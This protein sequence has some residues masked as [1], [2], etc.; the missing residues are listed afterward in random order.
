MAKQITL[1]QALHC[2]KCGTQATFVEECT[3]TTFSP[4][5]ITLIECSSCREKPWIYC[6][7]CRIRCYRNGLL[8]HAQRKKHIEQHKKVYPTPTIPPDP[9]AGDNAAIGPCPAEAIDDIDIDE[10]DSVAMDADEFHEQMNID[11]AATHV[12]NATTPM[13]ISEAKNCQIPS[14]RNDFPEINLAGNQWLAMAMEAKNLA[15]IQD[16]FNAF[17]GAGMDR[18]KNF[19]VAELGSGVG[20]CGGGAKYLSA[21]GFQ[22]SKDSQLDKQRFPDLDEALWHL[23]KM[24]QYQSMNKKQRIRQSRIDKVLLENSKANVFF[25][26][27]F[28]PTYSQLG[29]FYGTT[30]K[31]S[32]WNNLPV[33]KSQDVGG[34]AYVHPRAAIAYLL[35]NGIPI[36]E[37]QLTDD[38][39]GTIPYNATVHNARECRKAV[40]WFN[41][42]KRDYYGSH[43]IVGAPNSKNGAPIFPTVI[44]LVVSDWADGFGP[45]KVKNNRNSV[46]CKTITVSPPRNTLSTSLNTLPVAM[47]LKKA[48]G[49]A[50]VERLFRK[51]LEELTSTKEP[52]LFYNG[53]IQKVIPCFIRRFAVL[54]DKIERNGLTGT[55]GCGSDIHR[56]FAY[57]G[58]IQTP[59]CK[60]DE[61]HR[62]LKKEKEGKI[63][64]KFGWSDVFVARSQDA[65]GSTFPSCPACRKSRLRAIGIEFADEA[66]GHPDSCCAQCADW[67]LIPKNAVRLDFPPHKDYPRAA[68]EGCSVVAPAGRDVFEEEMRL[69]FIELN[70]TVMKQAS[71]FAFYQASRPKQSWTKAST[72][73][74]LKHCGVGTEHAES[75]Y[76]AAK[77]MAKANRNRYDACNYGEDDKIGKF[78]FPAAWL[79]TQVTLHDHIEAPMHLLFLGLAES[80]YDLITKWLSTAPASAKLGLAP[81][82][83]ALQE[84]IKDLRGFMLSWLGAYPL[85]GK[86]GNLGTGS[87]VAENWIC[88]V[89]ISQF[90]FGWCIREYE[91]S[92][93][94]GADDMSRVVIA[95]HALV[96]RL[97]THSGVKERQIKETEHYMKEFLSA[98]REFDIRVR[99]QILNASV[100]RAAEN[101]KTEAW[102]LKPNYM[103]LINLLKIMELIGPLVEWWDGGF[104]GE[105]FIQLIKPL[106][107]RGVREDVLSFF[108]NIMDKLYQG[109]QLEL[110]GKLYSLGEAMCSTDDDFVTMHEVFEQLTLLSSE[111][112]GDGSTAEDDADNDEE[113]GHWSHPDA[114]F[115]NTEILGMTK[116]RTIYIYRNERILDE[117]ILATK[118]LAGIVEV[119]KDDTGKTAFEFK[120]VFRK[121]VKEFACRQVKFDDQNGIFYHGMWCTGVNVQNK[122]AQ[123]TNSFADIQ[124]AAKLAAVAIPLWYVIG[125]N[126]PDSN[127]YC[128]ITNWWKYRMSD[129]WYRL[130]TLD[131]SMYG[132]QFAQAGADESLDDESV[133][134]QEITTD[135]TGTQYGII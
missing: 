4:G 85:T 51:D 43:G 5:E 67:E 60:L 66:L 61:I 40:D 18:M 34:V 42:I 90:I 125:K 57:S 81:F 74:Y 22:Q 44:C 84:L 36:D 89:R 29:K 110:M 127:K 115:S 122:I 9:P 47:G 59:S 92:K 3:D 56:R 64:S 77:D 58:K 88:F 114:C 118:P 87:W 14:S 12:E 28:I 55:L 24:A 97:L 93:M 130:P 20:R 109:N 17:S 71:K 27:T 78:H 128:V 112:D 121:P 68:T 123:S 45:G 79:S 134:D 26:E 126:K 113:E 116:E 80:N 131:A 8:Q 70:W 124:A 35:A 69:P 53:A 65:N 38:S 105:K 62:H 76:D 129:G 99:H 1:E 7:S 133:A 86:K 39:R 23:S 41:A 75:V 30:G 102:W 11:L 25:K 10:L 94:H 13:E 100:S 132:G 72:V 103:S 6:R 96:A 101:K 107:K 119:N 31:Y 83:N 52:I 54:S 2:A 63:T 120:L 46:D 95:F 104:K 50:D 33:P 73:C 37:V 106:I 135:A 19:W 117:A 49:W 111:G 91:C 82:K 32:M 15:T 108:Q 16:M 21:I 48:K 98:I